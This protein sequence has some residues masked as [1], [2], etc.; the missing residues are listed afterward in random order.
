MSAAGWGEPKEEVSPVARLGWGQAEAEVGVLFVDLGLLG[1]EPDSCLE[2]W[3]EVFRVGD[4]DV[5]HH[6]DDLLSES[7]GRLSAIDV[8][9]IDR[10]VA[11]GI[12]GTRE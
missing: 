2:K 10:V 3:L 11:H 6:V 1:K 7:L 12:D 8:C 4:G 5:G 9:R